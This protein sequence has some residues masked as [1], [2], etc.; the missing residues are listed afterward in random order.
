MKFRQLIVLSIIS[1]CAL[2]A[3]AAFVTGTSRAQ[4]QAGVAAQQAAG[5]DFV[6]V[7]ANAA[8]VQP[9]APPSTSLATPTTQ[10]LCSA[11]CS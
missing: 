6:A 4:I 2:S 7:V 9:L 11:S 1:V 10:I 8:A 5:N 3:Q